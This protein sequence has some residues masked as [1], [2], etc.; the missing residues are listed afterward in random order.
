MD[1]KYIHQDIKQI[2]II[3]IHFLDLP[4]IGNVHPSETEGIQ[5]E[6]NGAL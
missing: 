1:S 4:G 5:F 3:V 2:Y 6:E